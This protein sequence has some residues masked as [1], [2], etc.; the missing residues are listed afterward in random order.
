MNQTFVQE[1]VSVIHLIIVF[2]IQ[3]GMEITVQSHHVTENYQM[4]P[5]FAQ[6]ME[7]VF[8]Q[9]IVI[10]IQIGIVNIVI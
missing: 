7:I 5:I 9:I 3:I 6:E 4:K 10:V 1:K 8:H 2:V